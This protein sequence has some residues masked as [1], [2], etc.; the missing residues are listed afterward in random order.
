MEDISK[1][2]IQSFILNDKRI[3]PLTKNG[4]ISSKSAYKTIFSLNIINSNRMVKRKRFWKNQ[5]PQR[6]LLFGWKCLHQVILVKKW[7]GP[8]TSSGS[9]MCPIC[10]S[11]EETVEHTIFLCDHARVVWFGFN[12]G[13]LTYSTRSMDIAEWWGNLMKMN[14]SVRMEKD[15]NLPSIVLSI[16][17]ASWKARNNYIFKG[18]TINPIKVTST[19]KNL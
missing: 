10:D 2:Y 8:K 9:T 16:W 19:I 11:E 15:L 7:L 14:D 12:S 1:I 6:I 4:M 17:W 13:F 3:L 5:V 18:V